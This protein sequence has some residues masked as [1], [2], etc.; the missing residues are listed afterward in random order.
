MKVGDIGVDLLLD[1]T[2]KIDGGAFL[3]SFPGPSGSGS[4]S[5]ITATALR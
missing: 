4:S 2:M 5:Q 1:G 3:V